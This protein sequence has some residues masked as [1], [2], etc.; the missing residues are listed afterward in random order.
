MLLPARFLRC[1]DTIVL[2]AFV[3]YSY[4]VRRLGTYLSSYT[5]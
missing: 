5:K 3:H 2:L 1:S 4:P